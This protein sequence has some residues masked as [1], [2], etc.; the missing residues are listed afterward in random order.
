MEYFGVQM[1]KS[2]AIPY[3]FRSYA[4]IPA[5]FGVT[6]EITPISRILILI[7]GDTFIRYERLGHDSLAYFSYLQHMTTS[8][9]IKDL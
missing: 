2:S 4:G 1:E 5:H 3:F 9:H 8:N 6:V 7:Q